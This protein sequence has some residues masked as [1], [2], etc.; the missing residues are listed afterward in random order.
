MGKKNSGRAPDPLCHFLSVKYAL[1]DLVYMGSKK[2][3]QYKSLTLYYQ[4][5]FIGC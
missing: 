5:E 1:C 4:L 3:V 2:I